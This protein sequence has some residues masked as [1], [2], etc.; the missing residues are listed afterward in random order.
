[1]KGIKIPKKE[2]ILRIC[3]AGFFL[4]FLGSGSVVWVEQYLSTG[5][6]SILWAS[7]PIWLM[8]M[9]KKRWKFYLS[10]NKLIFGLLIGLIGVIILFWD[11]ELI[12]KFDS[13]I[14]LAF[15]IA[16][17]GVVCFAFGSLYSENNSF[18]SST[19]LI[20]AIQMIFVGAI[21]IV[22]SLLLGEEIS[23]NSSNSFFGA[24]LG[25]VYLIIVGSLITFYAY[26]WLLKSQPPSIVGT[27][28]YVNPAIA[29]LLGWWF[30]NENI[31]KQK[32]IALI[33]IFFG[34]L[35][36]NYYKSKTQIYVQANSNNR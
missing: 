3:L 11:K 28:T 20:V 30:L 8:A 23:I 24:V 5:L 4:L 2:E 9:D 7:L 15:I 1:L 29:V 22:I 21:S 35:I 36:V 26:V 19:I 33:F 13:E 32:I 17:F 27:Y 18:K 31:T 14:I 10:N 34:V 25:L 12:Q 16:I 6:T